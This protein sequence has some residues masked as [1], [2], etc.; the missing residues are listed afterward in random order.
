MASLEHVLELD[1]LE[2]WE[3]LVPS[4]PKP[5]CGWETEG[6]HILL[7][8]ILFPSALAPKVLSC[9]LVHSNAKSPVLRANPSRA[10]GDAAS[11]LCYAH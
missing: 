10:P 4:W 11:S 5:A 8:L 3:V 2:E 1:L 7:S 9:S 6:F